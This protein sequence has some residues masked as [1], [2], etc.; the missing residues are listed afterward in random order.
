MADELQNLWKELNPNPVR[1]S[2][3]EVRKYA[4]LLRAEIRRKYVI[5]AAASGI[6]VV[7]YAVT[8][9]LIPNIWFRLGALLT[10]IWAGYLLRNVRRGRPAALPRDIGSAGLVELYRSDL[11]RRK[12]FHSGARFVPR[13]LLLLPGP[14]LVFWGLAKAYPEVAW[15]EQLNAV[16][17]AAACFAAYF[18][19]ARMARKYQR[20]IE[21]LDASSKL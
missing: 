7:G 2:I 19:N 13:L 16:F 11:V 14:P 4:Q 1:L 5:S 21:R 8:F 10:M 18:L 17:F 3:D 9:F 6:V 12:D 15:V 20:E